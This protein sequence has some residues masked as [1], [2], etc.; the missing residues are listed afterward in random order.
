MIIMFA[1]FIGAYFWVR[2]A[3]LRGYEVLASPA[4]Q[5]RRNSMCASC[6]FFKDGLCSE[7]GCLTVA[8]TMLA[9][10]KCPVGRWGRVWLR[11]K[12]D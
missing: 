1:R 9:T 7:C 12:K 2:W 4:A 5:E 6:D 10:E 11:K 8:K 3:K